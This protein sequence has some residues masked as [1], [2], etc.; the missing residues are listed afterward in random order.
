[1][2]QLGLALHNYHDVA[3]Q[4]PINGLVG[5]GPTGDWAQSKGSNY[6]QLLPYF[7]QAPM[8]NAINW[9]ALNVEATVIS[10]KLVGQYVLPLIICPSDPYS[11]IMPNGNGKT[12]YGFSQGAQMYWSGNGCQRYPLLPAPNAACIGGIANS[13]WQADFG[14]SGLAEHA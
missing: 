4:F 5:L 10:G 3:G 6:G 12:T 9:S 13:G 14:E 11:N 2:K 7:D 8:Y 1:L